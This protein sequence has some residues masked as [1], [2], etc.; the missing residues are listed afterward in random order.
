MAIIRV[1]ITDPTVQVPVHLNSHLDINQLSHLQ[2]VQQHQINPSFKLEK[3]KDRVA[4][5]NPSLDIDCKMRENLHNEIYTRNMM[6]VAYVQRTA[7]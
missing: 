7:Y 6:I 3:I 5:S 1:T 2:R 4:D